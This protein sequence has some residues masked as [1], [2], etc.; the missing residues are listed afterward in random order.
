M[1]TVGS[2]CLIS[3]SVDPCGLRIVDSEVSKP[4]TELLMHQRP[5]GTWIETEFVA[6]GMGKLGAHELNY[7][8]GCRLDLC[9][10]I[11]RR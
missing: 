5:D 8:L 2:G 11:R 4:S 9:L 3:V 7:N 6:I 1:E 10:C